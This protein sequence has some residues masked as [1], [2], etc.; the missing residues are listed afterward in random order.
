[1]TGLLQPPSSTAV[2]L[3]GGG[4]SLLEKLFPPLHIEPSHAQ[5]VLRRGLQERSNPM[6]PL[7]YVVRSTTLA[8]RVHAT[9]RQPCCFQKSRISRF[10]SVLLVPWPHHSTGRQQSN[11]SHDTIGTASA[12]PPRCLNTSCVPLQDNPG[13]ARDKFAAG[14]TAEE[15]WTAKGSM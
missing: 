2:E 10:A 13:A 14:L 5:E 1:M 3:I 12:Q 4:P 7:Y 8:V 15:I 11:I 9:A 6:N